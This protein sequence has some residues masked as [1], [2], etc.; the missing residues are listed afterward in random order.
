VGVACATS[1]AAGRSRVRGVGTPVAERMAAE[2]EKSS[3]GLLALVGRWSREASMSVA[4][5]RR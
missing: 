1:K 4:C 3:R 5:G 2:R